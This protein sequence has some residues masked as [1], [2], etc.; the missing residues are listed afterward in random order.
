MDHLAASAGAGMLRAGGSAADAAVATSAVLAVT[1]QHM[2]GMGGDLLAVVSA[3]GQDP[4]ALLA[5]GHAGAGA[6]PARLRSEGHVSMPFRGDIRT[7]TVPG[8]VDGWLSLHE[9]FG[10]LPLSEVL[11]PAT[12]LAADGF[13]VSPTLATSL[14]LVLDLAGAEDYRDAAGP[15]GTVAPGSV[16]RRPGVAAALTAIAGEG[17]DGFYGG[18]F[19]A[20]LLNLAEGYFAPGDLA[21]PTS[22][23]APA[24]SSRAWGHDLWSAPPPSQG[25]LALASAWMAAHT[26]LPGDPDDPAWPHLLVEASRQ[27][28]YDRLAVLHEGAPLHY[29]PD[30]ASPLDP[31]ALSRRLSAI[32]A[33]RAAPPNLAPGEAYADGDTTA[34]CSVD[35]DR[36]GVSLIQSNAAGFGAH[37]VVPGVG[38]FL[39]NRGIGFSLE[40]GSPAEYGPGRRPPHTLSP[41]V[42]TD[43]DGGLRLVAGS[44][45]GDAQPQIL[46]QLAARILAAGQDPADAVAAA[47]FALSVLLPAG[48]GARRTGFDTWS[49]GGHVRVEIE[50][51][52][53]PSW[54]PGLAALGHEVIEAPAWSGSFGHAHAISVSP[55]D[56]AGRTVLAG[57]SDPRALG[58]GAVAG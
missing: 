48:D 10:R 54:S 53:P 5:V 30:G 41:L 57:G 3:P 49:A 26:A 46:L 2:C 7:V 51:H 40:P 42:A 35:R 39:Q 13:P 18:A 58:G 22:R 11:E 12:A 47:R 14:R 25:Y 34:V 19:G 8:C 28:G 37:I 56:G 23:W 17:R 15:D 6:D 50:G 1:S 36:M 24:V 44:M 29:G 45:G 32:S 38:I 52:A 4:V 27:A 43:T 16:V 21:T 20:G 33:S 31:K 55:P 9:R